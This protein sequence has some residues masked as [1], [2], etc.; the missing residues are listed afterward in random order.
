MRKTIVNNIKNFLERKVKGLVI[1][2]DNGKTLYIRIVYSSFEFKT[3]VENLSILILNGYSSH[4]IG[5]DILE[6]YKI[7]LNSLFFK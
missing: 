4:T 7:F 2:R 1:V 3:K 6:E 5:Y